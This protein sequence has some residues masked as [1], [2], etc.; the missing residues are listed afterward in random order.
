MKKNFTKLVCALAGIFFISLPSI[1]QNSVEMR[2][3]ELSELKHKIELRTGVPAD[4]AITYAATGE[5]TVKK[6][7]TRDTQERVI[8][9]EIFKWENNRWVND[10]KI[11]FTYDENGDAKTDHNNW[12]DDGWEY[13]GWNRVYKSKP[14]IYGLSNS[15]FLCNYIPGISTEFGYG[16]TSSGWSYRVEETKNT[17]GLHIRIKFHAY[18]V[19]NP[20][21]SYLGWDHQIIYNDNNLPVLINVYD[22]KGEQV[23]YCKFDYDS[24]GNIVLYERLFDGLI[25][26][27]AS[28]DA[29][30]NLISGGTDESKTVYQIDNDG[31]T[32]VEKFYT[33]TSN[34]WY[35][36]HYTVY[37]PNIL[38]PTIAPDNN[39]PVGNYNQGGFDLD[40]N[41]PVD[42]ISNGSLT[43]TF[44]E[45]FT[46]DAANTSLTLDFAGNFE[47]KITKQ[48]NNSWL[49][50]IKPKTTRSASLRAGEAKT[51]LH[52]AYKVDDK[53]PRGTYDISVNSILFETKGGNYI[54]EPAITLQ[55]TVDRWGVGNELNHLLSPTVYISNQTIYIQSENAE[56]ISIYSIT[57]RKLYET[58]IQ[59]GM[60]TINTVNFPQ[61]IYIVKGSNGWVR[62][63]I[64][65]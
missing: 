52:V 15:G 55:S 48:E 63:L 45:G 43:V 29:N 21:N 9:E 3:F 60:N 37:Y 19:S 7:Y 53:K 1:G 8:I 56:Q 20:T 50:E 49:L 38:T 32:V 18:Q 44:P 12:N 17:E 40:V 51:L 47:L 5:K 23:T 10:E 36:T 57:G 26:Y 61:G 13:R 59:T 22:S 64:A 25:R 34:N 54:P 41:I 14:G 24:N 31:N 11:D 27:T 65:K 2:Q 33:L 58:A 28:Y 6:V 46:L 39:T 42:S 35:M 62:K 30:N 4:S 16:F